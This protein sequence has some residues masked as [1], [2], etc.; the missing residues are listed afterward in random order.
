MQRASYTDEQVRALTPEKI[1]TMTID[2]IGSI[3]RNGQVALLS[4]DQIDAANERLEA[5]GAKF[6]YG[7]GL[8]FGV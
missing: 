5:L 2:E 8:A 1:K 3:N 7:F 4:D 6:R